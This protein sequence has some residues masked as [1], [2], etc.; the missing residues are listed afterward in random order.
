[1]SDIIL[2]L[3]TLLSPLVKMRFMI[4][5]PGHTHIN[6]GMS[7]EH[8]ASKWKSQDLNLGK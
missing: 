6:N 7:V 8:P 1:M 2:L 4:E 5:G 3:L